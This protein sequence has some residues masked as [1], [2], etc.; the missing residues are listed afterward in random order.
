MPAS[1]T[2][3]ATQPPH[4]RS[5]PRISV[6][7]PVYNGGLYVEA[8]ARS[9]LDQTFTDLELIALDDGSTDESRAILRR[10]ADQDSRVHVLHQPN[11][12]VSAARNAA[13]AQAQG[14]LIA[15]MDADDVAHPERLARTLAHLDTHPTL[16][17]VAAAHRVWFPDGR[18]LDPE[19]PTLALWA[20]GPAAIA[21]CLA[22]GR[23]CI[24]HSTVLMRRSVFERVGARYDLRYPV[25]HD[26]DL[27]LRLSE[28]TDLA[29]LPEPLVDY[30]IHDQSICARRGA[31]SVFDVERA[32]RRHWR[33]TGR[34]A[35]DAL[36]AAYR[37]HARVAHATGRPDLAT[38]LARRLF[39]YAPWRR[40]VRTVSGELAQAARE[41]L[42]PETQTPEGTP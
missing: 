14:E 18:K 1:A 35:R 29:C 30:R 24:A 27:W 10:L 15:P 9:I 37:E 34:P 39:W 8:A 25:A 6:I 28:I 38:R 32:L 26:Y 20:R 19:P 7:M 40:S 5:T 4:A 22:G 2:Q 33:R 13:Y 23:N 31:D 11:A 36:L 41:A 16:G 42:N 12:G 17:L 21:A 3:P